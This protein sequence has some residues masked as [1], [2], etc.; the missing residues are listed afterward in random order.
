MLAAVVATVV[1]A[2]VATVLAVDTVRPV[3]SWQSR[4]SSPLQYLFTK[5]DI[6][7]ASSSYRPLSNQR[8]TG[9]FDQKNQLL[10]ILLIACY[11]LIIN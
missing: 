6:M 11:V 7:P 8:Q 9:S 10:C 2:M 1:V 4:S 5:G 3:Q